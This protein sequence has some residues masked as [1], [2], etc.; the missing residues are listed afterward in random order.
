MRLLKTINIFLSMILVSN[1]GFAGTLCLAGRIVKSLPTYGESFSNAAYLAR[2]QQ[3]LADKIK[4]ANYFY[5][6]KPLE[7]ARIYQ[8]MREDGCNAII[9][10]EYLSDLL[11]VAKTQPDEKI[12]IFS[13]YASTLKGDQLPKNIFLFMPLY[14]VLAEKMIHFLIDRFKKIDHV[15]LMTEID[16]EE[17]KKYKIAYSEVLH[18]DHIRFDTFDFLEDDANLESKLQTY[19]KEKKYCFIFLLAGTNSSSRIA[20]IMDHK[21][22]IFIGTENFGS[23]VYQ[24]FYIRLNNKKIQSYFIRNLDFLNSNSLLIKF[25]T[26][27]AKRFHSKPTLLSAYTYEAANILMAA[28]KK[29]GNFNSASILNTHFYGLTGAS[30]KNHA[31]YR[32]QN[33]IVLSVGKNGY[34]YE[35]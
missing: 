25:Q 20:N 10:F 12:T 6:N 32:S 23:S 26:D 2:K 34:Q 18:K 15:M 22:I 13:S 31:F 1:V 8:K 28:Y 14:N 11:L 35:K 4:I 30:I 24:S 16:R 29:S 17:M 19:L 9:G 21:N 27:Y 33:S 3:G 7:P 5:D